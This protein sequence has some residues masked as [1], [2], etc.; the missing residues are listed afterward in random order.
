[1]SFENALNQNNSFL[2]D[3]VGTSPLS[4]R[5]LQ[6]KASYT[7]RL[8]ELGMATRLL[9]NECEP[10]A[11]DLVLARIEK[12]GQ[13]QK[14]ELACGR[15]AT[16][17]VGDEVVVCYGARYA[18]D[19]FESYVP[20]DL[21]PCD[22]VAAGGI[23]SDCKYKHA[24][25]KQPTSLLPL[26][27]LAY[28][29]GRRI[30]L[31][32]WSLP[33]PDTPTRHPAVFA[34]F[35]TMMNSGKTTCAGG[36]IKGFKQKGLRVG[37]A[38]ITGTG[39]GGDRWVFVDSGADVVLDFTDLGESSTFGL[40]A[41]RVEQIF[42]ELTDHLAMRGVDVIVVEV[43]DGLFQQETA[44]F[45]ESEIFRA[46]CDGV[47]FAASDALGALSGIQHLENLGHAVL[48]ASGKM[49]ASPIATREARQVLDVPVV[50]MDNLHSGCWLPPVDTAS[51]VSEAIAR[52]SSGKPPSRNRDVR[53]HR[54]VKWMNGGQL[55]PSAL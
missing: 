11:G 13:H 55:A 14:I 24:R 3:G 34:V 21:G 1:V 10:K 27:L 17:Y 36:L 19:Q 45:L 29:D 30:N 31:A 41:G 52:E 44:A 18:S 4:A 25:M 46:R 43:A 6:A 12:I 5:I 2:T 40:S 37:A 22:L 51:T 26:G 8:V 47:L 48:A 20:G 35:G 9:T 42:V 28:E 49:T 32:D 50:T 16:L 53:E 23:A 38:K 7:T 15:R 39:A 54:Y 33:K